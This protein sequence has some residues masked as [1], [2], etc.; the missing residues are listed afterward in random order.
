MSK[1]RLIIKNSQTEDGGG[2]GLNDVIE[3]NNISID[4]TNPSE[5]IINALDNIPVGNIRNIIG[6][7]Q[8]GTIRRMEGN[9]GKIPVWIS[10]PGAGTI[11]SNQAS[12]THLNDTDVEGL[13]ISG[14]GINNFVFA[15]SVPIAEGGPFRSGYTRCPVGF[16]G[17]PKSNTLYSGDFNVFTHTSNAPATRNV[18]G[19]SQNVPEFTE[20]ILVNRRSGGVTL[21]HNDV[22]D[23]S[24]FFFSTG[25]DI[26]MGL[27][28]AIKLYKYEGFWR[29]YPSY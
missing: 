6:E 8:D 15:S 9:A 21:L 4:K 18:I 20:I 11:L 5:P 27:Y 3:G 10:P 22:T 12:M 1:D 29:N 13:T 2:G 28:E 25:L 26:V 19:N 16:K 7:N 23:G 17:I 24:G 14:G